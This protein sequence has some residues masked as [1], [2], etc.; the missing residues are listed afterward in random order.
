MLTRLISGATDWTFNKL[1]KGD[2]IRA[3]MLRSKWMGIGIIF[4]II[5]TPLNTVAVACGALSDD[6]PAVNQTDISDQQ[7]AATGFAMR[8]VN[9]WLNRQP[10]AIDAFG[11]CYAG[12]LPATA[13][14][15]GG[16][17]VA[18]SSALPGKP[19]G[20]TRTWSVVI[21][22]TVP[23]SNGEPEIDMSLQVV[24][25]IDENNLFRAMMLPTWLPARQPGTP[26]PLSTIYTVAPG[27][28]LYTTVNGFMSALL[29]G[30]GDIDPYIAAESKSKLRAINPAPVLSMSIERIKASQE[31]AVAQSVPTAATDVEVTVTVIGQTAT[32]IQIP[33]DYPLVMSVAAGR[34]QVDRIN[35]R[36]DIGDI[37]ETQSTPTTTAPT[38]SPTTT[39]TPA[40]T[41]RPTNG[42]Q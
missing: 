1:A 38:T 12:S 42:A 15:L 23:S 18:A 11:Q 36:P 37:S 27:A 29:T 2:P 9:A 7:E 24:V 3:D 22:G 33:M 8:C 41:Q 32:G 30:Q 21:D 4:A 34:W 31:E 10:G 13:L 19:K 17:A 20:K 39:A 35:D 26:T 6:T 28:P 5:A 14:P 40:L 25:S 16:H